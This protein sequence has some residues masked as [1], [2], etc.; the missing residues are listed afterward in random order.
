MSETPHLALIGHAFFCGYCVPDVRAVL[1]LL[2]SWKPGSN[3]EHING[4]TGLS[5]LEC[6]V[7][8]LTPP[9]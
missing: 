8:I 6:K 9:S 4:L 5:M 2:L 7:S 3:L 1:R